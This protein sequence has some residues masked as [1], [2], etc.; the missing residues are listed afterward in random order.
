MKIKFNFLINSS[1]DFKPYNTNCQ[2]YFVYFSLCIKRLFLFG[3][4]WH[5]TPRTREAPGDPT[6]KLAS[7]TG[8]WLTTTT[9][10]HVNVKKVDFIS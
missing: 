3:L 10:I 6:R 2:K 1:V 7:H 8:F 5:W 9:T 4:A